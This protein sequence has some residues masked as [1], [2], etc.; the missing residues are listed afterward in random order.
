[1]TCEEYEATRGRG[2]P[3]SARG[4]SAL[5]QAAAPSPERRALQLGRTGAEGVGA[6]PGTA[7]DSG[8][9]EAGRAGKGRGECAL[10]R[11]GGPAEARGALVR[12][13]RAC[14]VWRGGKCCG[15][16]RR[17]A[18]RREH[19]ARGRRARLAGG[20]VSSRRT[21]PGPRGDG[22]VAAAG[23]RPNHGGDS[24]TES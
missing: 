24:S 10:A 22:A 9:R 15:L 5:R 6:T 21:R 2:V 12:R 8:G 19:G 13:V 3:R 16:P 20:T 7:A 4:S 17:R 1:M 14:A 18:V 23:A 11:L